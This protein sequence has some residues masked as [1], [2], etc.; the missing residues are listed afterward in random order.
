MTNGYMKVACRVFFI[1]FLTISLFSCSLEDD[2]PG[3]T[4]FSETFDFKEELYGFT[5]GFS[6][7]PA[8][9]DSS[10]YELK[11]AYTQEPE[12]NFAIML[13]GNNH[14]DDLFMFLKKR[15]SGLKPSTDYTITYN[16]EFY[17]NARAN[18]SGIAPGESVYLKVGATD[19]EPKS[20]IDKGKFIMN[21][22]KGNQDKDGAD[23]VMIG[24]V[25]VPDDTD[26][27]VKTYRSNASSI[28]KPL[29]VRT[30][31]E[32]DL[33]LIVGTD[34]AL[35]GVTTLFYTSINVVLSSS[36]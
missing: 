28:N 25:S 24:N 9:K 2:K 14:S 21:I 29:K 13:S 6:D 31:N 34:S 16:V 12:G 33:W 3:I 35:A 17:S 1:G 4:I 8:G 11:F 30:N 15:L 19:L 20:V 23:M 26:G 27:Y 5:G 10:R 32:G 36:N 18:V 22:D 7:F